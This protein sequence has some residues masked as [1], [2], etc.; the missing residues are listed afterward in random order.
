MSPRTEKQ[1][2]VIREEKKTLI[3]DVALE[4]FAKEGYFNTTISHIAN[5]PEFPKD[6]MYNYFESKEAFFRQ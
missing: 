1:F 5:M 3:M 6:L 4:H 2:Q